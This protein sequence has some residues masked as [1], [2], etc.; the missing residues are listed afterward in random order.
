MKKFVIPVSYDRFKQNPDY[1]KILAECKARLGNLTP[2][3][4][5]VNAVL[6]INA[7]DIKSEGYHKWTKGWHTPIYV[8]HRKVLS[9]PVA[10]NMIL[11]ALTIV[12]IQKYREALD[13][14]S[15]FV[16]GVATGAIGMGKLLAN[17]L[18]I[19]YVSVRQKAKKHGT[20]DAID[21]DWKFLKEKGMS[22]VF[23]ED[24]ISTAGSSCESV[25]RVQEVDIPIL[26]G[27]A[28]FTYQFKKADENFERV[29]VKFDTL[30]HY[31]ST[32]DYCVE[33]G[34][35]SPENAQKLKEWKDD[36]D[37]WSVAHGGADLRKETVK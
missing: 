15:V 3:Q 36:P 31:T 19:P 32:I 5:Y 22:T 30:G 25:E 7:L 12:F 29:G 35:V 17:R 4:A 11:D 27:I 2:E 24:L 16:S 18:N 10:E 1:D 33:I 34:Y 8:N 14:G 20:G 13:A 37:K 9:H 21:G 23:I 28:L 26:G 6:S